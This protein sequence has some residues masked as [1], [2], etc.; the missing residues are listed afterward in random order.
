MA[1]N[2]HPQLGTSPVPV[3]FPDTLRAKETE[4]HRGE[5]A[6]PRPQEQRLWSPGS[7]LGHLQGFPPRRLGRA[8]PGH[9]AH[10]SFHSFAFV[11]FDTWKAVSAPIWPLVAKR[12]RPRWEV[13][14]P[15]GLSAL[16]EAPTPSA[17]T[18]TSGREGAPAAGGRGRDSPNLSPGCLLSWMDTPWCR[19]TR[20][21]GQPRAVAVKRPAA[22]GDPWPGAPRMSRI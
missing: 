3:P 16:N 13:P 19:R 2:D 4:S 12:S 11:G 6:G 8:P 15:S 22:G 7:W 1:P 18:D 21:H 10:V 14:P 9:P 17:H 20:V 5:V